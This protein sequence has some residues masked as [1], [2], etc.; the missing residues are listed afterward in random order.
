MSEI[1]MEHDN[2]MD[3]ERELDLAELFRKY[4]SDK[5]TNGYSHLYSILFDRIRN[6]N[7]NVLEIGIGTMVPG[8]CSSM[9]YYMPND[10]RPGASL[11]AWRDYFKNSN[12]YGIDIQEDTQF[13]EDR[14]VTYLCNSTNENSVNNVMLDVNLEFDIIIDDGWHYDE[15]QKKHWLISCLI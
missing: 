8:V 4:G 2:E 14:I 13:T 1:V 15:A 9:K 3:G 6:N 12:I 7:L 5:D 10:Y 11:R